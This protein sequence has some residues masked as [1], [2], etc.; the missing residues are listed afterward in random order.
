MNPVWDSSTSPGVEYKCDN[1]KYALKREIRSTGPIKFGHSQRCR[2]VA[3]FYVGA[4]SL[5]ILSQCRHK[6]NTNFTK[7]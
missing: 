5:K 4:C 7:S 2:I 3:V 6:Q 1:E